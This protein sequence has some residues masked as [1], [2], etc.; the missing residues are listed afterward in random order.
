MTNPSHANVYEHLTQLV[1]APTV[2]GE[3]LPADESIMHC[4]SILQAAGMHVTT[5]KNEGFAALV[6]SSQ[7]DQKHPKVMLAGHLD[8]VAAELDQFTLRRE[9]GKLYGRG[10]LDMKFAIACF[11]ETATSLKDQLRAYDFGIMLTTDEEVGGERG[12]K[13]LLEQHGYGAEVVLLP[14]GANDWKIESQAQGGLHLQ[15][16][17]KGKA[18]HGSRPWEA[19]SATDK[20]LGFLQEAR[21]IIPVV[22]EPSDATMTVSVL[23]AGVSQNQVPDFASAMLDIR[24]LGDRADELLAKFQSIA[25]NKDVAIT[26]LVN[27]APVQL[28]L[29]LPALKTWERIVSEVRGKEHAGYM[30][31]FAA[32]D[33]RFFAA[34]GI[35]SI[36]TYPEGAGHHSDHEWISEESL[37]QFYDCTLAFVKS[38][39]KMS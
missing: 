19:D 8:V 15:I 24:F 38:E 35:Q 25:Q 32:S 3:E 13:F 9:N 21:T 20:L 17:A 27:I 28:D 37:Y 34:K 14:D 36:V 29:E 10:V 1:A 6:A 26:T 23:Q 2:S 16:I 18:A 22:H 4:S 33:A 30:T 5:F 31:S 11:L 39:A 7:K 12:V